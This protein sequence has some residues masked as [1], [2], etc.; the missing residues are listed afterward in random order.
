VAG[1]PARG[2][3]TVELPIGVPVTSLEVSWLKW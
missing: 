2:P 1:G 3:V